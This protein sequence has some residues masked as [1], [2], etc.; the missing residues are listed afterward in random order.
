MFF[1]VG[2]LLL[3][4]ILFSAGLKDSKISSI[5]DIYLGKNISLEFDA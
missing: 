2:G 4:I 3:N 5:F 1:D